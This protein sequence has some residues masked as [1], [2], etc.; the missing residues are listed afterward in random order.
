MSWVVHS[1]TPEGWVI[2]APYNRVKGSL[3]LCPKIAPWERY[4]RI[5]KKMTPKPWT[6]IGKRCLKYCAQMWPRE[7]LQ[8]KSIFWPKYG[9]DK[10]WV[11]QILNL[12]VKNKTPFQRKNQNML[13]AG[14][15]R[16]PD[17]RFRPPT[18]ETAGDGRCE[19]PLCSTC[20]DVFVF[21]TLFLSY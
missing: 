5:E 18:R 10:G 8:G 11:C 15:V 3:T 19:R 21:V 9:S 2:G 12:C 7:P 13:P 14:R 20:Y 16:S 17:P 1:S 4:Y 6:R